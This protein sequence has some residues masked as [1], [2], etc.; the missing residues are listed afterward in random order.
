MNTHSEAVKV[1]AELAATVANP[2]VTAAA[3]PAPTSAWARPDTISRLNSGRRVSRKV[4]DP[5]LVDASFSSLGP[6][7]DRLLDPLRSPRTSPPARRNAR[8]RLSH[9][10]GAM[11]AATRGMSGVAR[12]HIAFGLAKT[13]STDPAERF[14]SMTDAAGMIMTKVP[15]ATKITATLARIWTRYASKKI[16][17][18]SGMTSRWDGG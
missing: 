18:L 15:D 16:V 17:G 5:S 6:L 10:Q 12:I 11:L 3:S 8:C 2:T 1:P 14:P 7:A 9:A 13:K 4:G